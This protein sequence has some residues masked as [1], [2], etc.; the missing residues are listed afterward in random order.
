[1]IRIGS[2]LD[3]IARLWLR[4]LPLFIMLVIYTTAPTYFYGW[5]SPKTYF[6]ILLPQVILPSFLLCLFA[7]WQRWSWWTVF[8]SANI[9]WLMEFGFFFCQH[10]RVWTWPALSIAQS[11]PQEAAEYLSTEYGNIAK[12]FLTMSFSAAIFIA[13][14]RYWRRKFESLIMRLNGRAARLAIQ[15]TGMILALSVFYSPV[16][17][18][19]I[20]IKDKDYHGR[21]MNSIQA[22][23]AC[24]WIMYGYVLKDVFDNPDFGTLPKLAETISSTEVICDGP[25]DSLTVVYVVGESFSRNRSSLY[26]YPYD[27]NPLM[28]K[29]MSDSALLI[30]DNVISPCHITFGV[31]PYMLS[32]YDVQADNI[33]ADY[34]LLP[35]LMKKGGYKTIYL[36]N[37][38]A[39]ADGKADWTCAYFFN[40]DNVRDCSLDFYNT[41]VET[42]DVDFINKNASLYSDTAQNTFVIYHLMGQHK[43]FDKRYPE[44]F[45][46][47]T[48]DDYKCYEGLSE[49]GTVLMAEYD[50]ATLY[51]DYA[52]HSIIEPLRDKTAIIVYSPDHGEEVFDYRESW[53]RHV[54]TPI[55]SVRVCYEVPVMIWMSERF[56]QKYPDI[57][58]ALRKNAD[59]AIFNSDLPHTILD[60]AGI[61]TATFNPELSLIRDGVG[62]PHRRIWMNKIDYD[63][64]RD[65]IYRQKLR[66]EQ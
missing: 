38:T 48:K 35:A 19:T 11:N 12:A 10:Q 58:S 50:N 51:N 45:G 37:Q 13:F 36:D 17:I 40:N 33:Y 63:A 22:N 29:E 31:Y 32:T 60:I 59:K 30:F 25:T 24:T 9:L 16:F 54:S 7:G 21:C 56:R 55:T 57:V 4:Q 1:M 6:F 27:T 46:H 41:D 18:Y 23:S 64:S 43:L 15:C 65:E 49:R 44:D 5:Y 14:D 20:A 61:K 3:K 62:R 34:P 42:Y 28:A 47:F 52:L 26:G 2:F 8:V 66:Y 53:G 39:I